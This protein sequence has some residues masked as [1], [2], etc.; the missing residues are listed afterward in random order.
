MIAEVLTSGGVVVSARSDLTGPTLTSV[1]SRRW[2]PS[3]GSIQLW[4]PPDG[5]SSR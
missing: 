4:S 5:L 1:W 2:L 3:R